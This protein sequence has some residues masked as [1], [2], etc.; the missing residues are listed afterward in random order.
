MMTIFM[1][2]PPSS[3]PQA[4]C[5]AQ[6]IARRQA[7]REL[8]RSRLAVKTRTRLVSFCNANGRRPV[9]ALNRSAYPFLWLRECIAKRSFEQPGMVCSIV[10][11]AGPDPLLQV[12][13]DGQA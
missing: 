10:R 13:A 11:L 2:Q 5:R 6:F 4:Q 9:S 12:D 1:A 7:G 3:K 8:S